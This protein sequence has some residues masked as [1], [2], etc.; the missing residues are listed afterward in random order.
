M[1]FD[2]WKIISAELT[3]LY[4]I[5][6]EDIYYSI[7]PTATQFRGMQYFPGLMP[8]QIINMMPQFWINEDEEEGKNEFEEELFKRHLARKGLK[9]KWSYHKISNSQEG[10]KVNDKVRPLLE[11]DI[12]ILVFNFVDILFACLN[13]NRAYPR[14]CR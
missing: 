8:S 12:N 4:R 10:K 2:H 6:E 9:Y 3:G 14:S 5:V 13:G 1:R 11:N 7:L